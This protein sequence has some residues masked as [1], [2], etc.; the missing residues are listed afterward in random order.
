MF[1]I[2]PLGKKGSSGIPIFTIFICVACIIVHVFANTNADKSAL[3]FYP[4]R[5][6]PVRMFTSVFAHAD[7]FHLVGN[8]FF[9]YSFARTIETQISVVGYLLAF[10]VFVLATNL[11]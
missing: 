10:V 8:L 7:F 4:G 9:F 11:T 5:L 1:M 2:V 6:D 3:A